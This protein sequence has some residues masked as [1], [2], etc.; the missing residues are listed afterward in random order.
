MR[1]KNE[2]IAVLATVLVVFC[3]Y[4]AFY[5]RILCKPSHAGFWIILTLGISIGVAIR[6]LIKR[7]SK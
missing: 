2:T 5:E 1:K 3:I 6:T 4:L 7:P